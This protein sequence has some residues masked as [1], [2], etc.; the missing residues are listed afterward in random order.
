[1]LDTILDWAAILLPTALSVLG[2]LVSVRAPRSGHHRAWQISLVVVGVLTSGVVYWQQAR[3]RHAHVLEIGNLNDSISKVRD[4][5]KTLRGEQ[6][7]EV[8]RRLQAERD[9][10]IIVQGTGKSTRDGVV[11][12]MRQSPIKVELSGSQPPGTPSSRHIT[13]VQ[14]TRLAR[15]FAELPDSVRVQVET[16]AGNAEAIQYADEINRA[17]RAARPNTPEKSIL[18]LSWSPVPEG[19]RICTRQPGDAATKAAAAR[20]AEEMASLGIGVVLNPHPSFEALTVT[21][22]VGIQPID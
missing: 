21:I 7:K 9:L 16:V 20:I 10:A 5:T 15:V 13:K 19:V 22:V 18:G 3:V 17:L 8:A 14:G 6:E 2:V 11:S 12:D 1:M 4:E